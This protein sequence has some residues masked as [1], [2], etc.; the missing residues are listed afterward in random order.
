M[1]CIEPFFPHH[2]SNIRLID[3]HIVEVD[4]TGPSSTDSSNAFTVSTVRRNPAQAGKVTASATYASFLSSLLSKYMFFLRG[5][6]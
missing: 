1:P 3:W 4:V 6:L 2:L 5:R